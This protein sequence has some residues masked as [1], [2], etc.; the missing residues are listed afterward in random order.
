MKIPYKLLI[1]IILFIIN[2]NNVF[3]QSYIDSLCISKAK[4]K[5]QAFTKGH[6]VLTCNIG[7]GKNPVGNKREEGDGKT[8]EGL[9]FIN[10]R[11]DKSLYNKALSISYPSNFDKALAKKRKVKAG[12]NIEIHG[13]PKGYKDEGVLKVMPDWTLGCIAIKNKDIEVLYKLVR[14]QCTVL[15]L[16]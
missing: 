13:L 7:L 8:P 12:S 4:R 3:S 11:S 5:L 6:L 1:I 2:K 10:G 16:P 15:I 9:Y 14:A